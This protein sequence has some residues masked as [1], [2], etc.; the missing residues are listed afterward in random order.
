MMF[1]SDIS[2]KTIFLMRT[3]LTTRLLILKE[4]LVA[5]GFLLILKIDDL[6]TLFVIFHFLNDF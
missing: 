6:I 3:P 1:T 4:G 5:P 2:V